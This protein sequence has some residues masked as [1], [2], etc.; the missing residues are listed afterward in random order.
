MGNHN[1]M[2]QHVNVRKIK[3]DNNIV[4]NLSEEAK[5]LFNQFLEADVKALETANNLKTTI[6]DLSQNI[7]SVSMLPFRYNKVFENVLVKNDKLCEEPNKPP[8][9][10]D[11]ITLK[12][13]DYCVGKDKD[14]K[15]IL[16]FNHNINRVITSVGKDTLENLVK[17]NTLIPSENVVKYAT[18]SSGTTKTPLEVLEILLGNATALLAQEGIKVKRINNGN[19]LIS[20]LIV[21]SGNDIPLLHLNIDVLSAVSNPE[22]CGQKYRDNVSIREKIRLLEYCKGKD[23]KLHMNVIKI[24]D[25]IGSTFSDVVPIVETKTVSNAA[26]DSFVQ[27]LSKGT[28]PIYYGYRWNYPRSIYPGSC[29][30]CS[31]G[32]LPS[33]FVPPAVVSLPPLVTVST[34]LVATP[35]VTTPY[36]TGTVVTSPV[37]TSPVVTSPVVTSPVVTSPVITSPVVTSPVIQYS[38][39]VTYP[40]TYYIN[41]RNN[42]DNFDYRNTNMEK[43]NTKTLQEKLIK[44][45]INTVAN[46][47][48]SLTQVQQISAEVVKEHCALKELKRLECEFADVT[49]KQYDEQEEIEKYQKGTGK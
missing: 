27:N 26:Y 11:A 13:L 14:G 6:T 24:R 44:N 30:G 42:D 22:I 49:L 36:V 2:Q 46:K 35:F 12:I 34:P 17:E 45:N 31:G 37:V 21:D 9:T 40:R 4:Q 29:F 10:N 39:I 32:L 20:S 16:K 15:E 23:G 47:N 33:L 38:P 1:S 3:T 19:P 8:Q 18:I 5:K 48:N 25:D 43:L 28:K 41:N 7:K